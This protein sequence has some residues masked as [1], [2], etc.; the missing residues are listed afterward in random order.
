[1]RRVII[2]KTLVKQYRAIFFQKL[3]EE[4]MVEGVSLTVLYGS[5]S[6]VEKKKSDNVDLPV[7]VGHSVPSLY[8]MGDRL[9]LQWP[10]LKEI[11][12]ADLIIVVNANRNL[13]NFPLIAISKL[14]LIRLAFWG[15]GSNHQAERWSLSEAIK[16]FLVVKPYWWFA[17]TGGTARYLAES[18][19][20]P[21]RITTIDNAIDT[22]DFA[23]LVESVTDDQIRSMRKDLRLLETDRLGL[24]CGSLYP[25]KRLP[26]LLKAA[27]MVARR[28]PD[29]KI[30][31]LGNGVEE[32]LVR[33]ACETFSFVRYAGPMFGADKA[34]CYRMSDVVMNPGLVGLGVLDSFAAAVPLVT[35]SDSLH[36]PEFS[37]LDDGV[38][39][40]VV[41]G[42]EGD[43]A[44]CVARLILD[45]NLNSLLRKGAA[46]SS[47]FY[48]IENMVDNV[49]NGILKC[50][51]LENV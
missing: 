37:Y 41:E 24:Y 8:L 35:M 16:R 7:V 50:I 20:N 51:Q 10:S 11:I 4:L 22:T 49:K 6:Q 48:T 30:L 39:G 23:R 26:F 38:N 42:D 27:E 2:I 45:K 33:K 13:I 17:Y 1:M 18:G 14:G 40:M 19:F 9:L 36:S 29:F 44:D 21:D 34:T 28:I 5:P 15:H 47:G 3:Y 12:K 31:I 46:L 43:Y 25:A 32:T